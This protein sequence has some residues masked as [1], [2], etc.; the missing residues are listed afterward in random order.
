MKKVA[1]LY[2]TI[3]CNYCF[4]EC[5]LQMKKML[6]DNNPDYEFDIFIHRWIYNKKFDI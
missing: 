1:I 6:I 2:G 3:H 4:N 5:F